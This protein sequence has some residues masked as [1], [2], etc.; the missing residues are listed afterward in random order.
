M[1]K[2]TGDVIVL[3]VHDGHNAGAAVIRNGEVL[4]ALSEERLN[5]VKN[6]SGIPKFTIKKV[7]EIAKVSPS[8][9]DLVTV[10]SHLRLDDPVR[11]EGNKLHFI[12]EYVAPFL[13]QNWFVKTSIKLLHPLR[14]KQELFDAL[15]SAGIR[16]KPLRF[17]EHHEVHAACAYYGRP[18]D[19]KTL[20]LTLDG[21]GD[22]ISATV[23]IGEGFSIKRI[24]TTSFYNSLGNI[25]FSEI[26]AYLGMKRWEHE[27]KVMGLAP[28]GKAKPT[29]E[30]LRQ[31]IRINPRKPLEFQN[32]SG[33][34][35]KR[36]QGVY[37]KIL[38]G[39]R[40]DN[41]AAATQQ[42]FEE[43]VITWVKNAI[44]QT[45]IHKIACAGGSFLNVKANKLIRE[46]AEVEDA[47]FYPAAEDGGS[48]VGA[49]LEGYYRYCEENKLAAKKVN[50][51]NVYYGQAFSNDYIEEFLRSKGLL[52]KARKVTS[53]EVA[54]LLA[55][56]KIIA[57]FS[58]RD[59]WGPR[60]LGNRSIMAD[61][62][63]SGVIRKINFAIK[64]RDF[65][66]PFTPSILEEDQDRYI[67]RGYFSPY[68][69][70]AF[71]TTPEAQ[72]DLIAALHPY[73]LTARPQ[74]V[75]GWNPGWQEI[76]R[77]FKNITGV[78]G[79]LN[80]SFNL[81]GYPVCG[82]PER[83]YWTF[84]NSLLDGLLLENWL[85]ER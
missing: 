21:M 62:R 72:R 38:A 83:A 25:L 64:Q 73:D 77:E 78:G 23:S 4:A 71:D 52:Q 57:R 20:V 48:P 51:T 55:S 41:I 42:L 39:K 47:F 45:G 11:V 68:M 82:S 8:D 15:E 65:W 79:I 13:H 31:I 80:T 61:P 3:G 67:K 29:I 84:E 44:A 56:G 66:M 2:N 34:Y 36:M 43:L 5:N 70:E 22:G 40:F 74:T 53:R 7:L 33:K 50:V 28:Y 17:I 81:H 35:L 76:I 26:T 54:Q 16:G 1:A 32:I 37:R 30:K 85:I 18:W 49:A 59:E 27:Y 6:F 75:N 24:A 58:G 9:V 14:K 46:L 19:D 69:I 60:A 10:G 12:A 63:N